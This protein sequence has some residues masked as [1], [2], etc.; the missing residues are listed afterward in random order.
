MNEHQDLL[1]KSAMTYGLALGI[2]WMIKFIFFILGISN[3]LFIKIF[4]VLTIA[5][6][7]L[8][9]YFT[10][11]YRDEKLGGQISFFH[12]WRFGM[13]LYFFAA[14][15]VSLE[16]FVIFQYVVQHDFYEKFLTTLVDMMKQSEMNTSTIQSIAKMSTPSP[17]H[18]A[19]Q[20]IF[21]NMFY[22]ILLSLPVAILLRRKNKTVEET[23]E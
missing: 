3:P 17:I 18:I 7:F 13:M 19:V 11:K 20:N 22:G 1:I 12:A 23:E 8:A 4:T 14:L 6:P 15:V 16:H 2:F 10:K 5:V 9:Y 21:N